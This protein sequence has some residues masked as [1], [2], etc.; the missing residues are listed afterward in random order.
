MCGEVRGRYDR[1]VLHHMECLAYA[2]GVEAEAGSGPGEAHE[3]TGRRAA[4]TYAVRRSSPPKQTLVTIGSPSDHLI[5]HLA[6]GRDHGERAGH[7]RRRPRRCRRRR[8][9]SESNSC[10]PGSPHSIAPAAARRVALDLARPGH[11][12][13]VHAPGVRLG[14][15]QPRAVG[16]EADAVRRLRREHDLADR[17]AVGLR[18]VD[19]AEVLHAPF[20]TR[21]DR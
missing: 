9:P 20:A 6:R 13:R 17:R 12:P 4:S 14:R 16:R 7:Q 21:R 18:V 15:V 5:E 11:V 2:S 1:E 19:R 10:I 8:S 3:A